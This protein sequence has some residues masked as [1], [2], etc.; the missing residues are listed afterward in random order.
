MANVYLLLVVQFVELNTV[1]HILALM[2][3]WILL[4]QLICLS[5][6]AHSVPIVT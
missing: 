4:D 3:E 5:R 6:R 1:Y 2:H